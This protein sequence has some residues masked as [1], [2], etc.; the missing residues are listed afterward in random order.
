MGAIYAAA[1]EVLVVLSPSASD[2]LDNVRRGAGV[3]TEE[4]LQL[5]KDDWIGRAWTYQE[6]VNSTTVRSFPN[7]LPRSI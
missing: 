1:R 6:M 3:G 4:L 2:L 7:E 5:E